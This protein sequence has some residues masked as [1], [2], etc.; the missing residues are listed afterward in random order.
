MKWCTEGSRYTR[1]EVSTSSSVKGSSKI[2]RRDEGD[3]AF[4]YGGSPSSCRSVTNA[5]VSGAEDVNAKRTYRGLL[6]SQRSAALDPSLLILKLGTLL[7]KGILHFLV[8]RVKLLF[9]LLELGLLLLHLLL[10]D[11]LHLGFHLRELSL[12]QDSLLLETGGR[13]KQRKDINASVKQG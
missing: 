5:C 12:V 10:E 13:A 9:R 4:T 2:S 7:L 11:H 8:A 3:S 6:R 1:K